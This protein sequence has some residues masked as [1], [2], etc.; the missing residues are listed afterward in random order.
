M[1]KSLGSFDLDPCASLNRPWDTAKKHYTIED[2]G[3]LMPWD[4]HR[5][6]CNP[7]YRR[8]LVHWLEKM[9]L[10]NN[11]IS[12]VFAR[13]ETKAFQ[14]FVFHTPKAFFLSKEESSFMI[15]LEMKQSTTAARHPF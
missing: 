13:T 14:S 9:A 2:D 7:P 3:L 10:H 1:I 6:W 15:T 12:L 4:D 11:G 5:V 8:K